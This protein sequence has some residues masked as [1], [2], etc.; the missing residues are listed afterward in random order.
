MQES[1]KNEF[2]HLRCHSE[3]SITDGIVK[4]KDYVQKASEDRSPLIS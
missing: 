4:I 1:E 3:Y 2:I